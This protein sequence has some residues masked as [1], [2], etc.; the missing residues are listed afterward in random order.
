MR[1]QGGTLPAILWAVLVIANLGGCHVAGWDEARW[2]RNHSDVESSI[3]KEKS[4]YAGPVPEQPDL[5]IQR[6]DTDPLPD[7]AWLKFQFINR[8]PNPRYNYR[9]LLFDDGQLYVAWHSQDLSDPYT[10][11]DTEW[12]ETPSRRLEPSEVAVLRQALREADFGSQPP[13]QADLRVED[14]SFYVV[15]ARMDGQVHE[16]I[17]EAVYPSLLDPLTAVAAEG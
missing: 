17:Y 13:Y 4:T 1:W 8:G 15:T 6:R 2:N 5:R 9:W 11:F 3:M 16:V 12:P 7:D 10:P 14:G